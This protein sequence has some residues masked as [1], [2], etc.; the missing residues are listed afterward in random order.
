MAGLLAVAFGAWGIQGALFGGAGGAGAD[1]VATVNGQSVTAVD[2]DS[3]YQRQL[4][5]TARQM[6]RQ[7]GQPPDASALP[8]PMKREIGAQVLRQLVTERAIVAHG[9][10]LGLSVP[11]PVLRQAVFAIPQ[12]QGTDGKFDRSKFNEVLAASRLTEA[13][14]LALVRDDLMSRALIEPVRA[15]AVA[16]GLLVGTLFDF[17]AEQRTVETATVPF[18]SIPVPPQPTPEVLHRYYTN[19]PAAFR[20]PELRKIRAVVLSPETVARDVTVPDAEVRAAYDAQKARLYKPGRRSVQVVTVSSQAQAN[21]IAEMWRG[22]A[23]W[24]SVE[25]LAASDKGTAVS[26][27]DA[28]ER[29]FPSASLGHAVFAAAE[30]SITD[31]TKDDAGW[32]VLRVIG[33]KAATGDYD[34]VKD[35]L[36]EQLAEKRAAG[37]IQD[38]VDRLQDAVAGGGLDK[39]PAD[40]GAV[41]AE[42]TL[43]AK[44]MTATGEPAPLPG[45]EAVRQ[46]LIAHAFGEAKGTPPSLLQ[47][48]GG[49]YYAVEVESITPPRERTFDEALPDVLSQWVHD[50][51]RHGAETR[52][53][54]VYAAANAA[55][56]LAP[57]ATAAGL[58]VAKPAPFRRGGASPGVPPQ[59]ASVAFGLK[60]GT[61]TMVETPDSFVVAVVTGVTHPAAASTPEAYDRLRGEVRGAIAN[62]LETGYASYLVRQAN[63][64]LN[65]AVVRRVLGP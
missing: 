54:S 42:G 4:D 51:V 41:A 3:A 1:D 25:A 11:D 15:S 24:A 2:F 13:R 39:I 59:L 58:A 40:L 47:G 21:G 57:A 31:P 45:S 14:L 37:A 16:P 36:R 50:Q 17:I 20:T 28:G 10:T 12:F 61:A 19:H 23:Q 34:S 29:E 53:A 48:P 62:D 26:L 9:Q 56:A 52:A 32:V 49:S 7:G 60:Q 64:K 27:A 33:S 18:A 46:A 38:H 6:A 55:H 44:G 65:E 30:G 8:P 5:E 43:D 63:P 22:G 35:G